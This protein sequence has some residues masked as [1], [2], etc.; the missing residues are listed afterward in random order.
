M[1]S[2]DMLAANVQEQPSVHKEDTLRTT[3]RVQGRITLRGTR[4]IV[5]NVMRTSLAASGR[6]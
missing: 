2:S 3:L 1:I 5:K 4:I 6:H